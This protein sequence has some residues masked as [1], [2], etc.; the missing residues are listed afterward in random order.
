MKAE[1]AVEVRAQGL[2]G[3]IPGGRYTHCASRFYCGIRLHI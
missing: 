3:H 1:P 2:P